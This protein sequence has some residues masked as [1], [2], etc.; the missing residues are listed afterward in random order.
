MGQGSSG[1]WVLH[2]ELDQFIVAV[3]LLDRPQLQ[4]SP[5]VVGDEGD[6]TRRGV[7]A[8]AS[9]EARRYGIHSGMALRRA[10]TRCAELV[11]LPLDFPRYLEAS[12]RVMAALRSL[13]TAVMEVAG[14]DE[15]YLEVYTDD[16]LALARQV[17]QRVLARTGLSC[18]VGSG[19][20]KLQAKT[21]N[22]LAKP[23]GIARLDHGSWP[24]VM[25]PHP[26]SDL[27]GIGPKTSQ[28]LAD[29]GVRTVSALAGRDRAALR[30]SFGP[31]AGPHLVSLARGQDSSP[32]RAQVLPARSQGHEVTSQH[33]LEDPAAIRDQVRR[34]A[35]IV[36]KELRATGSNLARV[37]VKVRFAPCATHSHSQALPPRGVVSGPSGMR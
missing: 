32:V 26:V 24:A 15:A 25:G 17:R 10:A 20:N 14:W 1:C 29:L 30:G 4:G 2:V 16:P 21:A 34:L 35:T 12:G 13:R 6:L 31:V 7:V 5:V 18:A 33:D 8:G 37:A 27:P 36:S 11:C 28:R 9:Y 19:D 3:E 22:T 23:G